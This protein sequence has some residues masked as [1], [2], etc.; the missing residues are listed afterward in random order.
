MYSRLRNHK[1]FFN[2]KKYSYDT[3]AAMHVSPHVVHQQDTITPDM[4]ESLIGPDWARLL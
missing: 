4:R 1:K 2:Y 3:V